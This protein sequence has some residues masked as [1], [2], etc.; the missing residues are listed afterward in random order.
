MSTKHSD[1]EYRKNARLVRQQVAIAHRRGE[2][3]ACGR[4][5][6][7][8]EP[9]ERYDVGHVDEHGGHGIDNLRAE[10]IGCNRRHGGRLGAAITNAGRGARRSDR[11]LR[12]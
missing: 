3:V 7:P 11:L 6:R 9:G 10:H 5:P 8:I 2:D 4:C 1:P 12:W